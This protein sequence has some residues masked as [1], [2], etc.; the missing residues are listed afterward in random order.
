MRISDPWNSHVLGVDVGA[1][2]ISICAVSVSGRVLRSQRFPTCRTNLS[3]AVEHLLGCV[4][5]FLEGCQTKALPKCIGIGIRGYIDWKNGVWQFTEMIPDF[6]PIG[7]AEIFVQRFGVRTVIDNDVHS[8]ALAELYLGVGKTFEDFVYVNIGSGIAAGVVTG[9]RLLRG[10]NNYAGEFGG[11]RV[12]LHENG[13]H[14]RSGANLEEMMSGNGLVD[15]ARR[16]LKK[17]PRSA[18]AGFQREGKLCA[19]SIFQAYDQRDPLAVELVDRGLHVLGLSVCNLVL[20]LNPSVI[21][22]GGGVMSDG[23]LLPKL[24]SLL[25]D[26]GRGLPGIEKTQLCLSIQGADNVGMFGAACLALEGLGEEF[27]V[28]RLRFA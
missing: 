19:R 28:D 27:P 20:L 3:R 18:L 2:K 12:E 24:E 11:H 16:L 21:V 25:M 8:A 10:A 14:Y 7:L 15:G 17:Y 5:T 6:E 23:W 1:T 9:G 22:F 4:G 13:G 26:A